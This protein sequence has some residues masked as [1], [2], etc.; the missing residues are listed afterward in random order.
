MTRRQRYKLALAAALEKLQ[1]AQE[2]VELIKRYPELEAHF[3]NLVEVQRD[4]GE[5][6]DRLEAEFDKKANIELSE[7]LIGRVDSQRLRR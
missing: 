3:N 6:I 4:L 1:A 2:I 7:A 5:E